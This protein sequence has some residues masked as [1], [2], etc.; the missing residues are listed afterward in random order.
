MN[1]ERREY[2]TDLGRV[3]GSQVLMHIYNAGPGSQQKESIQF[4][5]Q[6]WTKTG[7]VGIQC[8]RDKEEAGLAGVEGWSW[9]ASRRES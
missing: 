1:K 6:A 9:R 7:R 8:A 3:A 2:L 4:R 5:A